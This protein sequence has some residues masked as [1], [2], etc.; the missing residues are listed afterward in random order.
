[1]SDNAD[2]LMESLE[3]N[4]GFR[5][6]G[7]IVWTSTQTGTETI[8]DILKYSS[9]KLCLGC[10]CRRENTRDSRKLLGG[11]APVLNPSARPEIAL[12]FPSKQCSLS[13]SS[14]SAHFWFVPRIRATLKTSQRWSNAS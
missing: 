9:S 11:E 6:G 4:G 5:G 1:M 13:V 10:L 8:N 2:T 12:S 3:G 14:L 7:G